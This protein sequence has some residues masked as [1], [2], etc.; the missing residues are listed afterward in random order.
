MLNTQVIESITGLKGQTTG[1]VFKLSVPRNEVLVTLDGFEIIPF[2]GLTSWVAFR[3][4]PHHVTL[5]GDI[6]V[7]EEEIDGALSAAIEA[8]LYVTALHNHF[9]REQP[10]AM[11]MHIE[12][13]ADEAALATGANKIFDAII[14]ARQMLPVQQTVKNVNS[15]LDTHELETIIGQKGEIKDGVFKFIL[16]RPTVPV[17][18]TRC[19]NLEINAAMG[20]N[21]WAAFQGT[22][23]RAAVC[24]DFAMIETEVR[25]VIGALRAGKIE[26]V[27]VHNHMFFEEP[28]VIFLH[29][30]GIGNAQELAKTFKRAVCTQEQSVAPSEPAKRVAISDRYGSIE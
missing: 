26:V 10:R 21:T 14:S 7:F 19:G 29:Y 2:M 30:W 18:C 8:G 27:A 1:D 3:Q 23:E 16:G 17:I 6:V 22:E 5:M 12:G 24:G 20:Y 15:S 9:V 13:T 25:S 4:G 28:R 11:F